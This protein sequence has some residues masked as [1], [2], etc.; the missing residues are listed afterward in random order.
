MVPL[1]SLDLHDDHVAWL[2]RAAKF[3]ETAFIPAIVVEVFWVTVFPPGIIDAVVRQFD[4]MC[5][6]EITQYQSPSVKVTKN[7]RAFQQRQF[8]AR[9][10]G[11]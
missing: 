8:S 6:P 5:L 2:W 9:L 1:I 11:A 4:A 10:N 7:K 3:T